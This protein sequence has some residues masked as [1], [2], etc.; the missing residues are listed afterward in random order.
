MTPYDVNK[1][2]GPKRWYHEVFAVVVLPPALLLFFTYQLL[3]WFYDAIKSRRL[4]L[5]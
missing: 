2:I 4:P 5:P 1:P 3:K